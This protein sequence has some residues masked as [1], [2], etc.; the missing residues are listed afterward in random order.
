VQPEMKRRTF[1]T[2]VIRT[3]AAAAITVV[4]V[5]A[6]AQQRVYLT[7]QQALKLVFPKADRVVKDDKELTPADASAIEKR[8]G[9]RLSSR[10]QRVYRAEIGGQTDGY[11]MIVEEIGKEQFITFVVG[12]NPD[13]KVR[14]VALM[15]FRESRGAEV[16]DVRFTNQ[17]RGKSGKDAIVIGVDVI[18]ITGA[19]LSSRAF[20]RGVKKAIL[21]CEA[22]YKS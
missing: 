22:F 13:F 15:V 16:E 8:L 10:S 2:G 5:P 19:T 1:V 17:F 11:A 12:I 20:C 18:G 14:R 6:W 3:A 21:I 9:Y 4:Q 7:E